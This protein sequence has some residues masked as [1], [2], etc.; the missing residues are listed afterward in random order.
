[1]NWKEPWAVLPILF[2]TCI[3]ATVGFA[4]ELGLH[5]DRVQA[6]KAASAAQADPPCV[7]S[8]PGEVCPSQAFLWRWDR[9][10]ELQAKVTADM[11]S[12]TISTGAFEDE[13]DLLNGRLDRVRSI[14]QSECGMNC[15]F[16]VKT[17]KFTRAALMPPASAPAPPR[18]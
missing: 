13:E 5:R 16:N 6:A 2:I 15:S 12:Q 9:M 7:A 10:V 3:C 11:K 18:K 14:A 1:M 17:R 8:A 4:F